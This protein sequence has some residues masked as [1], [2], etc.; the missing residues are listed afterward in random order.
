MRGGAISLKLIRGKTSW[1]LGG[2]AWISAVSSRGRFF[3]AR[4]H[5]TPIPPPT[6]SQQKTRAQWGGSAGGGWSG[7]STRDSPRSLCIFPSRPVLFQRTFAE[8]RHLSAPPVLLCR[9]FFFLFSFFENSLMSNHIPLLMRSLARSHTCTH[10]RTLR[11]GA[12]LTKA[13]FLA[14]IQG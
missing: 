3:S 14:A 7:H 12:L 2:G 13:L 1:I 11:A 4:V 6:H 5:Y 10:A 8:Q 9:G